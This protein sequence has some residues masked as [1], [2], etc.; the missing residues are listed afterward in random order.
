MS[1]LALC[2]SRGRPDA[3]RETLA[4]FLATRRDPGS[5]L[6][7]VVDK[8][9]RTLR[10]YPHEY[11]HVVPPTGCMGDAL[12][13][14]T[15]SGVLRDATSVGMIGDDNRFETPG[16]DI[17]FDDALTE[18]IGVVYGDDGFQHARLPTAWWVSRPLVDVFGIAPRGLRH[19]Y[20]DNWWKSLAEG[21]G[22]LRYFGDV[23]IPHLHPHITEGPNWLQ[24]GK[25]DAT[26][27]RGNSRD[28]VRN[29]RTAFEQWTRRG[30]REDVRKARR[31]IGGNAKMRVLADWHH[32]ALWESLSMLFEDRFGW[33]LYSMGGEDWTQ[34]AWTLSAGPPIGWTA[35]DYLSLKGA[36]AVGDHWER[37]EREYPARPR[38]MVTPEQALSSSWDFVL[39][40][41]PD[42]Q[43][44]FAALAGRL[45]AR[46]I[47]QVGN[48]KHPIDQTLEQFVLASSNVR[49]RRTPH[50]IYHQEF[51]R[52]VFAPS[53]IVAPMVVTSLMLR[54]DWTSC[55][56]RWLAEAP[57]ISWNA[58]GGKDPN[59]ATYLAPMSKVASA[60]A[61]SGWVWMD[62]RIGDG[63]GHT[64]HNAAAMGRPLIGHASHYKGLMGEPFWRD[65]ET[66]VDLDK[67]SPTEAL[68]LVRA[69]SNDPEWHAEM[70][71]NIA[72]TFDELVD[73]DAE[74][75]RIKE[76]LT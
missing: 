28:N 56:Y 24:S 50:V 61:G 10:S 67:H 4:S 45:G 34:H 5:R 59:A 38:K 3:A 66:C 71:A 62:K 40:S 57:G 35:A 1:I 42:H 75:D 8:D 65:L 13:R 53:P 32:P 70:G 16:W 19:L 21:A 51:D 60:I 63:Y 18:R 49:L 68:R 6:V 46:F 76:A 12:R 41:V 58:P 36:K 55:D 31:V 7:F 37:K 20:M 33:E 43:R 30:R 14:A 39:G 29:D 72:A 44:P 52:T 69:I 27:A 2:P 54:L 64:I 15:T 74:A 73:F 25:S 23:S 22:C 17:T 47:H 26:Y 9:D 48:A 11:T